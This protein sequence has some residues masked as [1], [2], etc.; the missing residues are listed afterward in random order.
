[1]ANQFTWSPAVNLASFQGVIKVV[2]DGGSS[3]AATTLQIK[4]NQY[5]AMPVAPVLH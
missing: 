5:L 4:P 3:V 2:P 1:M